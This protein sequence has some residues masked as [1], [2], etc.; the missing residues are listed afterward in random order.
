MPFMSTRTLS[1]PPNDFFN[2][3]AHAAMRQQKKYGIPP[4]LSSLNGIR[5]SLGKG[6]TLAQ[7]GLLTISVFKANRELA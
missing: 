4:P 7:A 6:S 5:K 3:Y 2:K 1:F